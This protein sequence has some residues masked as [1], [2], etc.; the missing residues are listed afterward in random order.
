MLVKNKK[1]KK[2]VLLGSRSEIG[3]SILYNLPKD[4]NASIYLIG[5][6]DIK[7]DALE[8]NTYIVNTIKCNLTNL[9]EV[10]SVIKSLSAI[11]DIDCL[12]IAAGYLPSEIGGNYSKEIIE[13]IQVNSLSTIL[14]MAAICELM[15]QNKCGDI[16]LISSVAAT[17]ARAKNF[18][19]GS[20][21]EAADF[22]AIGLLNKS[23][24]SGVNISVLRPGFVFTKLTSHLIP[25]HFAIEVETVTKIAIQGLMKKK[26]FIYAPRKLKIIINLLKLLPRFIYNR[27]D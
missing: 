9:E 19:Y 3:L 20:S 27:L 10:Q 5:K 24:N 1:Y 13:A 22:F 25:A 2:I 4:E 17:R 18:I 12:I 23:K 21:K 16:L 26:N 15:T 6:T 8:L 14:F 7:P 11:R